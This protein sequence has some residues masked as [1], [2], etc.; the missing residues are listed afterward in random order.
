M[1]LNHET[2]GAAEPQPKAADPIGHKNAQKV[3]L[4]SGQ[5]LLRAYRRDAGDSSNFRF[6]VPLCGQKFFAACDHF[7][8]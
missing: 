6:F 4:G 2:P 1:Q 3:R 7:R 5:K 8:R